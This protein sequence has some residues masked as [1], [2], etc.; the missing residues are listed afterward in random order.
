MTFGPGPAR[1]RQLEWS[2]TP[3]MPDEDLIRGLDFFENV[4]RTCGGYSVILSFLAACSRRWE[5]GQA[6][7]ILDIYGGLGGLS[8]ALT[9]WGRKKKWD[10]HFTEK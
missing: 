1:S 5:S 8:T 6:I 10:L 9:Q 4:D 3:Q 7:T 2:E